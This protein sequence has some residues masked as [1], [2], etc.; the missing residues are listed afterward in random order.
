MAQACVFMSWCDCM[1]HAALLS[2]F[3]LYLTLCIQVQESQMLIRVHVHA[4][5]LVQGFR[6]HSLHIHAILLIPSISW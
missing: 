1:A 4:A 2:A 3:L 6:A 5:H